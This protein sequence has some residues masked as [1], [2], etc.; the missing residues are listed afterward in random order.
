M[1]HLNLLIHQ[2]IRQIK[3][4]SKSS[5][6]A[7]VAGIVVT[8]PYF[9]MVTNNNPETRADVPIL[10]EVLASESLPKEIQD[11]SGS[12]DIQAK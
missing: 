4:L 11:Y 2:L 6:G 3:L 12:K 1:I 7:R 10:K 9:Y 8:E 5:A